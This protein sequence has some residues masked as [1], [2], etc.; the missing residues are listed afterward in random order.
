M[1]LELSV[2][3]ATIGFNQP[4]GGIT[5]LKYRLLCY[6]TPNKKFSKRKAIAFNQDGCCHL[7][8]CLQLILFHLEHHLPSSIPRV[9]NYTPREHL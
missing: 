9:V 5:N 7:V 2:R 6:V 8:L 4:L 1:P 3:D